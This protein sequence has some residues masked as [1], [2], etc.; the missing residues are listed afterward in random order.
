MKMVPTISDMSKC[1]GAFSMRLSRIISCALL[2]AMFT[3]LG[4]GKKIEDSSIAV[5]VKEYLLST[6][7]CYRGKG[8][9]WKP[10]YPFS[11][12]FELVDVVVQDKLIEG[13]TC[14]AACS[15]TVR[16]TR[17]Y[18]ADGPTAHYVRWLTGGGA[19]IVG[20]NKT[21]NVD[22]IFERFDK[23]WK[24]KEARIEY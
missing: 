24:I 6:P 19:G 5:Q 2:S 14:I 8:S 23:N 17:S 18:D 20:K 9:E 4:C 1:Y 21:N 15:I 11:D 22:F 10:P 16:I 3:S 7:T 12:F 13:R